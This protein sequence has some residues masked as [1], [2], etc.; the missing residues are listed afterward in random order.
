MGVLVLP[1]VYLVPTILVAHQLGLVR[2]YVCTYFYIQTSIQSFMHNTDILII[3]GSGYPVSVGNKT[4]QLFNKNCEIPNLP[5]PLALKW[6]G[7]GL[8]ASRPSVCGGI[9][10]NATFYEYSDKCYRL[11]ENGIWEVFAILPNRRYLHHAVTIGTNNDVLWVTGGNQ[12]N[13]TTGSN[14][15]L[16]NSTL[17]VIGD[18]VVQGPDLP[19]PYGYGFHC[20]VKISNGTVFVTGGYPGGV[21]RDVFIYHPVATG[22]L[23]YFGNGPLMSVNRDEHGCQAIFSKN[24]GN[25]EVVL[26]VG[27]W[28]SSA[29]KTAE[30]WD[31]QTEHSTWE[32]CNYN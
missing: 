21:G 32:Q 12:R 23:G 8:L 19:N 30:L 17:F 15:G 24:H 5:G 25:R 18:D 22:W 20:T 27:G 28:Y 7:G 9:Y 3:G 29:K 11:T 13:S 14:L 2:T 4:T 10:F 16:T 26:V 31:F 1:F 6:S